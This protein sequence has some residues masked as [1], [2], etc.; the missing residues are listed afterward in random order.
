M[1]AVVRSL[2][3]V[4]VGASSDSR[5]LR[6]VSLKRGLLKRPWKRP[7]IQWFRK[8]IVELFVIQESQSTRGR[9][10]TPVDFLPNGRARAGRKSSATVPA[11]RLT[12]AG[13][14]SPAGRNPS[15]TAT[16]AVINA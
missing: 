12:E 14:P 7:C 13:I 10:K 11:N 2:L 6:F 1:G 4:L 3:D 16:T 15:P 8:R 9:P 5:G